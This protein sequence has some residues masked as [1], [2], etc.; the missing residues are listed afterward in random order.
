MNNE[1]AVRMYLCVMSTPIIEYKKLDKNRSE[2]TVE[3][4]KFIK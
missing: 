4:F 3:L 1:Q 2:D